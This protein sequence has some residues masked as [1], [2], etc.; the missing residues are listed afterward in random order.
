MRW[1]RYR[2]RSTWPVPPS[3]TCGAGFTAGTVGCEGDRIGA[4]PTAAGKSFECDFRASL[5]AAL[6][7]FATASR[8]NEFVVQVIDH[9]GSSRRARLDTPLEQGVLT[10]AENRSTPQCNM[11]ASS[12]QKA[13]LKQLVIIQGINLGVA[14]LG[15]PRRHR[16]VKLLQRSACRGSLVFQIVRC[17]LAENGEVAARQPLQPLFDLWEDATAI[18]EFDSSRLSG[19]YGYDDVRDCWWA[20]D[21]LGR[22]YRFE[23]E[24][25]AVADA[26]AA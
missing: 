19:D 9:A 7:T 4:G 21:S 15:E 10:Q 17:I 8:S 2:R 13:G 1:S 16:A 22:M 12:E 11:D 14:E 5:G 20:S 23:V 25:V 26:V 18:A 24:Q 3:Q 6:Q